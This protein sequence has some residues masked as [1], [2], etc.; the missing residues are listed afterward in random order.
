MKF[1]KRLIPF[2]I[3]WIIFI[4]LLFFIQMPEIVSGWTNTELWLGQIH[5]IG[6]SGVLSAI[7]IYGYEENPKT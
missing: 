3:A 7:L 4:S 5:S 6:V 1:P 2:L